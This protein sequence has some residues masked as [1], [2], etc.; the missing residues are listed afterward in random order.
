MSDHRDTKALTPHDLL[1]QITVG[2]GGKP[3][4]KLRDFIIPFRGQC[5]RGSNGLCGLLGLIVN[6]Q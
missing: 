4:K 1:E 3:I 6:L 5:L 2:A